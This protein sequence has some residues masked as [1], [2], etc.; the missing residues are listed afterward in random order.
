[1]HYLSPQ[2]INNQFYI[3]DSFTSSILTFQ[4][5]PPASSNSDRGWLL[6]R[7]TNVTI[8]CETS[9]ATQPAAILLK[10]DK[11]IYPLEQLVE[12]THTVSETNQWKATL[13]I[14]PFDDNE[15]A[16]Y[17]CETKF[18]DNDNMLSRILSLNI[19]GNSG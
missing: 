3:L 15:A 8:T 5:T 16:K 18:N 19:Q 12:Q 9:S 14:F 13:V 17:I 11:I 7:E 1:M 2:Q 4:A 6:N 10:K